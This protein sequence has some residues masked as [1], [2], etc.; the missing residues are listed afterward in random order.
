M[1]SLSDA[2]GG[3]QYPPFGTGKIDLNNPFESF[4]LDSTISQIS[5]GTWE[6]IMDVCGEV[7]H[8]T[9][10]HTVG[11]RF[12]KNAFVK[13]PEERA[14]IDDYIKGGATGAAAIAIPASFL[15]AGGALLGAAG[16]GVWSYYSA[17]K[18]NRELLGQKEANDFLTNEN[19]SMISENPGGIMRWIRGKMAKIV[20]VLKEWE[21]RDEIVQ[22]LEELERKKEAIET[23]MITQDESEIFVS[24]IKIAFLEGE[25]KKLNAL[26]DSEN[27][28]NLNKIPLDDRQR[29]LDEIIGHLA[30]V[31][32]Q[33]EQGN[34]TEKAKDAARR[35]A[36]IPGTGV[37]IED[38]KIKT[39]A[40]DF[41]YFDSEAPEGNWGDRVPLLQS[42]W[43]STFRRILKGKVNIEEVAKKAF[44]EKTPEEKRALL[45]R[46][47]VRRSGIVKSGKG[48]TKA[49][50]MAEI[51]QAAK[52]VSL[53]RV[54]E[55]TFVPDHQNSWTKNEKI[56]N[57][58]LADESVKNLWYAMTFQR[59][60]N[61]WKTDDEVVEVV[62]KKGKT[63]R[64]LFDFLID[65]NRFDTNRILFSRFFKK[66]T[67][68]YGFQDPSDLGD[69]NTAPLFS[70]MTG[71]DD[72]VWSLPENL[73]NEF[74]ELLEKEAGIPE[75]VGK[76]ISGEIT[77]EN[78]EKKAKDKD[79]RKDFYEKINKDHKDIVGEAVKERNKEIVPVLGTGNAK[80]DEFQKLFSHRT[81]VQKISEE[82]AQKFQ[83][84][85]GGVMGFFAGAITRTVGNKILGKMGVDSVL[86][87]NMAEG[88]IGLIQKKK[89]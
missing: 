58:V 3:E 11:H 68:S 77:P 48:Q 66:E 13:Q 63:R 19:F 38:N 18:T 29:L 51:F 74:L 27:I 70:E 25:Q 30:V 45:L 36:Q 85:I 86:L 78:F 49:V 2:F 33:D 22:K 24:I 61:T 72:I 1:P 82:M 54:D 89:S 39:T 34:P 6:K 67:R 35:L 46:N 59:N 55:N 42:V 84:E 21:D 87:Q 69:T 31:E 4:G 10:I 7:A 26:L 56:R 50:R 60:R 5:Q 53:E 43:R 12:A 52:Q 8:G 37:V 14:W 64:I 16:A 57:R 71:T 65:E 79:F 75:L 76:T 9:G 73:R 80:N 28:E 32:E 23:A 17:R 62:L 88:L 47:L 20:P 15:G 40:L 41:L 44:Q 81:E 83:D